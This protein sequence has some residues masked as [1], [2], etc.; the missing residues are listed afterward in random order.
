MQPSPTTGHRH[1][2]R[3]HILIAVG[4]LLAMWIATHPYIGVTHDAR[5]Y[6]LQTL[7]ALDPTGW[8]QDLSFEYGTQDSFSLFSN[9]YRW[10]VATL[11]VDRAN[12]LATLI[13]DILWL[14]GLSALI[15][16]V[17]KKPVERIAAVAG[18]I[19]LAANYGLSGGLGYA[20]PFVTPRL[21]AEA[22]VLGSLALALQQRYFWTAV[23]FCLACA[24]HPLMA[25]P[26]IG[27]IAIGALQRDRRAWIILG[28]AL[29]AGL[30]GAWLGLEPFVRAREFYDAE[31]FQIIEARNKLVILS[32]WDFFDH[33][34]TIS[35]FVVLVAFLTVAHDRERKF[36][37]YLL[38]TTFIGCAVSFLGADIAH[39][40]LITNLQLWR[41]L[42]LATLVSNAAI[43]LLF[44]RSQG[45]ARAALAVGIMIS[46]CAHFLPG[47]QAV[48][49][50]VMILSI[51]WF[52][53]GTLQNKQAWLLA[54]ATLLILTAAVLSVTVYALYLLATTDASLNGN[55]SNLL[56]TMISMLGLFLC[57]W[58]QPP[59]KWLVAV[60]ICTLAAGAVLADQRTAW[61]RY[62]Y[63]PEPDA[64]LETFLA[65]AGTTYWEGEGVTA[66]WFK[67]RKPDYYSCLQG[68]QI[69]FFR[70]LALEWSRRQ[71]ILRSLNTEDFKIP[72]C[73][74]KVDSEARGPE[75]RAQVAAVCHA[76]P[77]LDT[78]ILNHPVPGLA[79]RPWTA[80]ADQEII[81]ADQE[82]GGVTHKRLVKIS[83][84]YRYSCAD[85]RD[86]HEVSSHGL[87]NH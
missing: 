69:L 9:G 57:T 20:E 32:S 33:A 16:S 19:M 27:L 14:T 78:V 64:G 60:M 87:A 36:T 5:Y 30:V 10:F 85:L 37:V 75:S 28:S 62:V 21:F 66:L 63:G 53:H 47:L 26:G 77:D 83:T 29:L 43:L 13:G 18:V 50:F 4:F 76:L 65:G 86:R 81:Q 59:V 84:F 38:A 6:L 46:V 34:R 56:L 3:P 73:G 41:A 15:L 71:S 52:L 70:P 8:N 22:A 17:L 68:A 51:L 48:A 12:L 25:I 40:V 80:P 23:L 67:A 79:G 1:I 74:P 72:A 55:P 58:R 11:G 49:P 7:H 2:S 35:V 61:N 82:R 31:W 54:R 42:W 44:L 45:P 24:L 39:H